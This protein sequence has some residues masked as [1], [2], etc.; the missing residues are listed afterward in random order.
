ME[1]LMA[2]KVELIDRLEAIRRDLA[3]GLPADAEDQAIQL[4]NM[5]VLQEIH[6]L[7]E[8]ELRA[9]E[10]ELSKHQGQT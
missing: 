6:R 9:I 3:Q 2:R 7:A 4:E 5:G 1:Q 10:Q 8:T